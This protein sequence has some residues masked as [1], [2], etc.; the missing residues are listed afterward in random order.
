MIKT[1][2][3]CAVWSKDPHRASLLEQHQNNL[4]L[5]SVKT[6]RIYIFENNDPPPH[7]LK[8][9]ILVCNHPLTIYEAWNLAIPLVRTPF[10]MNLNLDDRLYID[11][12][13]KLEHEIELTKSYLIGGDWNVTYSQ[14][15]TNNI[16]NC[17]E[18][19]LLP[20]DNRWPLNEGVITRLG[21][22]TGERG[23]YGPSTLWR[24]EC[25]AKIPRFPYRTKD[26]KLLNVVGDSIFWGLLQ[27]H[28]KLKLVRLPL[29]IGNYF[30]H[31][32]EQAEFRHS[33][34]W[35]YLNNGGISFI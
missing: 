25:H 4:D 9:S 29:V 31:P 34:E 28:F 11:S 16:T 20:F 13:E 35:E 5:L 23:T 30:H 22:G 26:G 1:T 27:N 32:T 10:L 19:N 12:V 6:N 24:I 33:D 14:V 8:G 3:I 15:D 18:S 2:I 21:S 17:F 7:F